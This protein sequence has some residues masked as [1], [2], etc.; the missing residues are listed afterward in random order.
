MHHLPTATCSG[1]T[2]DV[3][4][5]IRHDVQQRSPP[6]WKRRSLCSGLWDGEARLLLPASN[7]WVR[8]PMICGFCSLWPVLHNARPGT[9]EG[10]GHRLWDE[11]HLRHVCQARE[12]S[13][14]LQ[15]TVGLQLST[16]GPLG[17]WLE[18]VCWFYHDALPSIPRAKER[19]LGQQLEF[20]IFPLVSV[21][22]GC[23]CMSQV[24]RC[25]W[26]GFGKYHHQSARRPGCAAQPLQCWVHPHWSQSGERPAC[27]EGD[28]R[29]RKKNKKP[30]P[31]VKFVLWSEILQEKPVNVISVS[32]SGHQLIHSSVVDTSIVF[33]HRLGLPYKRALRNLM[34]DHLKRIIQ[35]N[36]ENISLFRE[37]N[38]IFGL[39]GLSRWC[40][41]KMLLR[42]TYRS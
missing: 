41:I 39:S 29:A 42:N 16:T 11:G 32:P 5:R 34:A 33:P 1:W 23:L 10:D 38:F 19:L 35:D 25:D 30:P 8:S 22:D 17:T 9:D 13:G 20:E 4:R 21:S 15:H 36:G 37:M 14:G 28:P 6:R 24:L 26:G 31:G 40:I 27:P 12:Q 18:A 3:F 2:Q 7:V